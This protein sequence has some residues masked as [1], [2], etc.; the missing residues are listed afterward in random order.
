LWLPLTLT[1]FAAFAPI[2]AKQGVA[3]PP[4]PPAPLR[5]ARIDEGY[6]RPLAIQMEAL[7]HLFSASPEPD[8]FG[9]DILLDRVLGLERAHWQ[10]L[11]GALGEDRLRDMDRGVAQVETCKKA[12]ME[13]DAALL[14][15][16]ARA[17]GEKVSDPPPRPSP[18]RRV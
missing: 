5:L 17:L 16:V 13:P 2:L 7:V 4:A 8:A 11:I 18:G 10:K 12:G 14:Q 9:V 15:G 6:T 3:P 1:L